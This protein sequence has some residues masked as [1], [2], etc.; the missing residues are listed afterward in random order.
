MAVIQQELATLLGRI[1]AV[2]IRRTDESPPRLSVIDVAILVTGK[3]ARKT[4][5]DIGYVKERFPEV[6]QQFHYFHFSSFFN[7]ILSL[8]QNGP[9]FVSSSSFYVAGQMC[10]LFACTLRLQHS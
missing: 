1:S 8:T 4:A 5:Q 10:S 9:R 7:A 2:S 3:D 6:A